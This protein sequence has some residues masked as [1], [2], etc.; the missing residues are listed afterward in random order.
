MA[1]TRLALLANELEEERLHLTRLFVYGLLALFFFVLG[2]LVLSLLFIVA[3]WETHRLAAMA[4]VAVLY[5]AI[6]F[7]FFMSARHLIAQK[8]RL[9]SATLAEIDKDLAALSSRNE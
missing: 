7:Y 1:H 9:F 6:A 4:G 8:P 2:V 5:L 3:F